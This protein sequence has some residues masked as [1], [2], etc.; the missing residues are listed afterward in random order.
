[1]I[2]SVQ[3]MHGTVSYQLDVNYIKKEF[4]L[5]IAFSILN[6]RKTFLSRTNQL[7]SFFFYTQTYYINFS[8]HSSELVLLVGLYRDG[9]QFMQRLKWCLKDTV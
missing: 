9:F 7:I 6:R 3:C 1:M 5:D 2:Y 4:L 8:V